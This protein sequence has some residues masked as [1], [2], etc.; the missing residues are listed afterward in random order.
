MTSTSDDTTLTS[1]LTNDEKRENYL[2]QVL[3]SGDL[4]DECK[5]WLISHCGKDDNYPP[6]TISPWSTTYN[7][8]G[9][10][11]L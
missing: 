6:N 1:E 2:S 9:E 7:S 8:K 10:T 5:I 11:L 4:S 3:N